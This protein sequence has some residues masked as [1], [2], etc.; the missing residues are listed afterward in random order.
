M[1]VRIIN[2]ARNSDKFFDCIS[3]EIFPMEHLPGM[4]Q[5]KGRFE[6]ILCFASPKGD[7]TFEL[8]ENDEIFYLNDSGKTVAIDR[9]MYRVTKQTE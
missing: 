5:P 9:R 3:S 4:E 2:K 6:I 1:M 7:R 8:S